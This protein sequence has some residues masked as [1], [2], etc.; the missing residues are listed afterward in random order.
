MDLELKGKVAV[1]V[2]G[3]S[4]IGRACAVKLV[5]EGRRSSSIIPA[6]TQRRT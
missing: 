3:S 6:T 2:G 4:N 1:V 5:E